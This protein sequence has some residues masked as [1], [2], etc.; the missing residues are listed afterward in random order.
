[1]II[2]LQNCDIGVG[3]IPV[4]AERERVIDFTIPF[5]ENVGQVSKLWWT[6]K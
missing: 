5:Y 1:M 6:P 3:A 2:S 4:Q